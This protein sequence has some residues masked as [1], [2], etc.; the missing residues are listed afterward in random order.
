[1]RTKS[2]KEKGIN[3]DMTIGELAVMVNNGF[4]FV[5]Q[6]INDLR[7]DMNNKFDA[8]DIR[9]EKLETRFDEADKRFDVADRRFDEFEARVNNRF[10]KIDKKFDII[11]KNMVNPYE[12]QSL[13]LRVDKI[14]EKLK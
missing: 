12:F 9:F 14:D 8:V 3:E 5:Q 7:I 11:D 1:M 10:D 4:T 2:N 6:Q 13:G